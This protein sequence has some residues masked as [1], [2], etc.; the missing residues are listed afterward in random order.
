MPQAAPV[1]L[2]P[3]V[4]MVAALALTAGCATPAEEAVGPPRKETVHAVTA[5]NQLTV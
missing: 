4:L 1:T 3:L 5:S 2:R